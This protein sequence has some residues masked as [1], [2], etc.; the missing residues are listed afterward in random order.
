VRCARTP[1]RGARDGVSRGGEWTLSERS[2]TIARM[3]RGLDS[4]WVIGLLGL[5]LSVGVWLQ[6]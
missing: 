3:R 1:E 2:G 4:P 5:S 6:G